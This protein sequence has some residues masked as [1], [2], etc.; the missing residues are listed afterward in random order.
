[1]RGRAA[2]RRALIAAALVSGPA[3]G[4]LFPPP[5]SAHGIVA[6]TDL[7]IPVWL[8]GWAAALVL[9]VSFAALAALW[10]TPRLQRNVPTRRLFRIPFAIDFVVGLLGL[11]AFGV[12]VYA[13]LAGVQD[14]LGNL[15]PTVIYV[16]FWVGLVVASVLFGN[17]WR[18]ISPWRSIARAVSWMSRKMS[19]GEPPAALE[20]PTWLGRWPAAIGILFFAWVELTY[21]NKDDPSTLSIMMLAYAVVMLVGMSLYG[22]ETWS[23]KADP[24]GVYFGLFARLAPL[25]RREGV[26]Y[27]RPPLA[28]APQLEQ[29]PGTIALLCVAIGSTTFDGAENGPLWTSI[30]PHL[31]S[32]F[33]HLGA[34]GV[35]GDQWAGTVGLL[36]CVGIVGAFYRLGVG[37]MSEVGEGHTPSEL[38]A[39]FAHTLI[40]I[41]FAYALAHYF[42]LL[43]FQ[44]QAMAHLIS[45]PLGHGDDIFGTSH[46]GID[47]NVISASGIWYVQVAAL[48]VGHVSGLVLAHD[49]AVDMYRDVRD[50]V[51]SQYWMLVVMVG[52]T[53][54]G[55]WLLS[56][57]NT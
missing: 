42:S 25:E 22:I 37:G 3:A 39:K 24:F 28:G 29:W 34:G 54:L 40:P 1:M 6:R 31:I 27:A 12:T 21:V 38:A 23:E 16:V 36:V 55:L 44:G 13:G 57:V 14:A 26:L 51:R 18:V 9:I 15:A 49:R 56:A 41:A 32:F 43:V 45:D 2:P 50:A 48:V 10:P 33:Q 47:Y 20:Y 30:R 17:V 52:F 11:A 46:T 19:S 35:K 4:A 8:F 5:A 53:S 7:P